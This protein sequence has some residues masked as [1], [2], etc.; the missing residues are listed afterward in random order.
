VLI[1]ACFAL[2]VKRGV[3]RLRREDSFKSS[4]CFI[5]SKMST[6]S[7]F[8]E[9]S[10]YKP[11]ERQYFEYFKF[12][13]INKITFLDLVKITAYLYLTD[14]TEGYILALM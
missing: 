9:L 7:R 13:I 3:K 10:T 12:S 8:C 5:I 14:T 1:I 2:H 4:A 6:K 11:S